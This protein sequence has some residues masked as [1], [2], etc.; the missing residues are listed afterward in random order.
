M[1]HHLPRNI[2]TRPQAGQ[3]PHPR[4]RN[5]THLDSRRP[6]HPHPR[7]VHE[8]GPWWRAAVVDEAQTYRNPGT[9][10]TIHPS[11][12]EPCRHCTAQRVP[13]NLERGTRNLPLALARAE[14]HAQTR[15]NTCAHGILKGHGTCR[16]CQPPTTHPKRRSLQWPEYTAPQPR[17]RA[18]RPTDAPSQNPRAH[19]Y[20]DYTPDGYP[21][22]LAQH[23]AQP[24]LIHRLLNLAELGHPMENPTNPTRADRFPPETWPAG[25]TPTD[26]QLVAWV[27]SMQP[28]DDP[29]IVADVLKFRLDEK[30]AYMLEARALVDR[31]DDARRY[32]LA[33]LSARHRADQASRRLR[34]LRVTEP[35]GW[36]EAQRYRLAW[37]S[38][39]RRQGLPPTS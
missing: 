2:P 4:R 5:R 38:A 10:C 3:P 36:F 1:A 30:A 25:A 22:R 29:R 33:W 28:G 34:I 7:Q 18:N 19:L 20:D 14:L 31:A 6:R 23:A 17:H 9:V 15:A 16:D 11:Q 32:R 24:P 13:A 27:A 21:G 26:A 12:L 35:A 39:R 37:H 8:D